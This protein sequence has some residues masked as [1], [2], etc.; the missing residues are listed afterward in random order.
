MIILEAERVAIRQL[1]SPSIEPAMNKH[2]AQGLLEEQ[3]GSY[4]S[5]GYE[6]LLRLVREP[7]TFQIHA[8]SGAAYQVE[9][10][11]VWD[12]RDGGDLRVMGAIDDGGFWRSIAPLCSDFIM[13]PD[14]TFVED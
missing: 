7:D 8:A 6:A 12:D 14:G 9:I 1:L 4:R 5:E 10:S 11:A 2:E 3:L 13:R